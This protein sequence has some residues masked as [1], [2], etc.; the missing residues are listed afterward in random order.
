MKNQH[1]RFKGLQ[2]ANMTP[3]TAP[4]CFQD[5]P[6]GSHETTRGSPEADKRPPGGLRMLDFRAPAR[7]ISTSLK[8]DIY[9]N[10]LDVEH[11]DDPQK[12]PRSSPRGR[13]GAPKMHQEAPR[14]AQE[15][16]MRLPRSSQE[17]SRANPN[18][19][20]ITLGRSW[21]VLGRSWAALGRSWVALGLLLVALG[22]SWALLGRS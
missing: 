1:F 21:A 13:Q 11:V 6:K 7:E 2:G 19:C 12:L 14:A 3:K 16:P 9:Y 22:R 17:S 15:A 10:N 5:G 20:W 18:R 8:H 4:R